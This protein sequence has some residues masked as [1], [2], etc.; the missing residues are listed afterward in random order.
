[1]FLFFENDDV[2][3]RKLSLLETYSSGHKRAKKKGKLIDY[4]LR[5]KKKSLHG[6]FWTGFWTLNLMLG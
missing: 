2:T 5:I 3:K 1:M 4:F 6:S